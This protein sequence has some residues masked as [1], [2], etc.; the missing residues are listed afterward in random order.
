MIETTE[1]DETTEEPREVRRH[2]TVCLELQL[3][4]VFTEGTADAE[5]PLES[6]A[7]RRILAENLLIDHAPFFGEEVDEDEVREL[8]GQVVH[9]DG[10]DEDAFTGEPVR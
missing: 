8:I 4:L 7:F 9:H 5:L 10:D 1:T 2:Y 6:A 3:E